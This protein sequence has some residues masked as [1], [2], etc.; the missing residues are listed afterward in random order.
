M[1]ASQ[2]ANF[3]LQ[4]FSDAG[5]LLSGGRLYTY[6]YGT[7]AQKTAYTDPAG[8]VPHTYTADGAGGQYIA[9]N[10]R[11][12]LPAPLYLSTGPYDLVLKRADGSTVWARR[13]D[14]TGDVAAALAAPSGAGLI[15]WLRNAA[16]AVATTIAKW[17]G[18]Q[19]ISAFEFMTDAQIADV[20]AGTLT[21]DVLAALQKGIDAV[22]ARQSKGV[23]LLP[24]GRY[25]IT[26]PLNIPYGVSIKG[27][28]GTA[29][30][31]VCYGCDGLHFVTYG[32]EIGSMFFEDFGITSGSGMNFTAIATLA[33]ASTMDGLYFNRLRFYG[34]NE[35]FDLQ[36]NWN[37][38]ITN[39]VGQNINVGVAVSGVLVALR[40][41]NNRFTCAAGGNGAGS[42]IAIDIRGGT[43]QES[44]HIVHNQL[45]GFNTAINAPAVS[46][47]VNILDNDISALVTAI[48]YTTVNG[49]LN[50]IDNYI[51]TF[52]VGLAGAAQSVPTP[53][54]QT[55]IKNNSFIGQ[56]GTATIGLQLNTAIGTNQFN[57]SIED[58]NFVGFLTHDIKLFSPGKTRVENNRCMSN[59]STY[60]VWVG[61]VGAGPVKLADNWFNK[62]LYIDVPADVTT[63]KLILDHNT[64]GNAF[65][66]YRGTFTPSFVPQVGAFGTITYAYANG[67]FER[68]GNL[69]FFNLTIV[70]SAHA[71]GTAGSAAYV[72]GLPFTSAATVQATAVAIADSYGWGTNTPSHAAVLSGSK[73][74][75][76]MHRAA[77]NGPTADTQITDM[78]TGAGTLNRLTIS[79]VYLCA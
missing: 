31:L 40:I 49:V 23:Y 54:T 7:T 34:W 27:E 4:E 47:F 2:P 59:V 1:S 77:S 63:G 61:G 67:S 53:T 39:C 48:S 44:I 10:A 57:T 37:C 5:L 43:I 28:G 3:N 13:A 16:A 74:I 42:K 9:L 70:E 14:P 71:T 78:A 35:C 19:P 69:C 56:G 66:P 45:Y 26:A 73:N 38:S 17:L 11:G 79:G 52:G 50:I 55:N 24:A 68:V 22:A 20:Q 36:A 64:E 25:K 21:L 29:S 15:G 76:L 18:W 75:A 72:T 58:N 62:A 51:E 12:E 33:N 8:A 65:V 46:V 41:I 60:S 32:Y 6:A 30:E